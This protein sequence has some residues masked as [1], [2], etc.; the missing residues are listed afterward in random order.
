MARNSNEKLAEIN[1]DAVRLAR[2]INLLGPLSWES[3]LETSFLYSWEKKSPVLP[4]PFFKSADHKETRD[5]LLKISKS[6][7]E[8][9][10]KELFTKKTIDSYIDATILIDAAGTDSFQELSIAMFGKPGNIMPGSTTTGL[11]IAK[12]MLR[13]GRKFDHPFVKE[14]EI[15]IS[16]QIIAEDLTEG[17]SMLGQDAP[18]IRI[19]PGF[20]SKAA[21]GVSTI[22]LR[23]GTSFSKYDSLQLL[24][25]EA[26][27]HSLTAI[28]GSKQPILSMMGRGAPRT[29]ETQEGLATFAEVITGAIDLKRLI[30]IALRVVAVDRALSGANFI[31]TFQFFVDNGQSPKESFWSAA[32]IFRGGNP[33]GGVVFTKDSVY[34]DGLLNVSAF[35]Q[36]ALLNNRQSLI[37]LLFCGRV[38]LEDV[39][40]L[41]SCLEKGE[42]AQ[43]LYLPNW[44][45]DIEKL[46]AN[47]AMSVLYTLIDTNSLAKHFDSWENS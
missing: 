15:C 21:A 3:D 39:F 22:T 46:A 19:V 32:R 6:L 18:E 12:N 28:N 31:E 26:M 13:V 20:P 44:Y 30:R 42:L 17:I 33:A 4:K 37:H 36:W 10:P 47:L 2:S 24:V 40:L 25:H 23:G 34:L 38:A 27:T 14:P 35:F 16:A 7:S 41:E 8:S 45:Q 43:P 9:D 29:T 1:Q 11:D 5:A